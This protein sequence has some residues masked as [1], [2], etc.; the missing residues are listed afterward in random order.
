M[1]KL[2]K[3]FSTTIDG[4]LCRFLRQSSHPAT[5]KAKL[6]ATFQQIRNQHQLLRF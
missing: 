2:P 1:N 5:F 6:F 3:C 4:T